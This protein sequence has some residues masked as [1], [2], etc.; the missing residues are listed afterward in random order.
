MADIRGTK[1]SPT[2]RFYLRMLM[3]VMANNFL[4]LFFGWGRWAWSRT[5]DRALVRAR[6]DLRNLSVFV[7]RV[8]LRVLLAVGWCSPTSDARYASYSRVPRGGRHD[9]GHPGR[10]LVAASAICI[11]SSSGMGRAAVPLHV[12]CPTRWK[13]HADLGPDPRATM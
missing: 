7:N 10:A 13:G 11:G 3:L 5:C 4:Q 2:L 6:A 1:S 8:A 9:R 12:W